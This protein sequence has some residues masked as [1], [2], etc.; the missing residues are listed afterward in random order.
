M[1]FLTNLSEGWQFAIQLIIVLIC[2]FYG[3]KKGGIG[4]IVLVFIF[5]VQPGK[6]ANI[7]YAYHLGCC[8]G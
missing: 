5:G 4:L 7:C 8:C 6:P 3:A 2:L 1:S